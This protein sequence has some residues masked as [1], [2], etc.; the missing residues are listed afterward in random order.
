[1]TTTAA[2]S[3]SLSHD[4][5][6]SPSKKLVMSLTNSNEPQQPLV[7]SRQTALPVNFANTTTPTSKNDPIV[8]SSNAQSTTCQHELIAS[9]SLSSLTK[10]DLNQINSSPV[11]A[12]SDVQK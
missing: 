7:L 8:S 11:N 1:M 4:K 12:P 5:L 10:S 6:M 3:S 9:S 2:H